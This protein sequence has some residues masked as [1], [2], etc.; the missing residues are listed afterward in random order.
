MRKTTWKMALSFLLCVVL[1]A[2][3]AL[4]FTG[5]DGSKTQETPAGEEKTFTF[6]V[7]DPEGKETAFEITTR[8]EVVGEALEAEGLIAGENGAYGLYVKTVNG[9]TLDYEKDGM[10]WAF[11]ENGG[12]AALGVD[13]TR[14]MEGVVYTF[15]A[16]AAS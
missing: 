12:Y 8:M 7:I 9:L 11:Y 3:A 2:A 5:C 14:I 4:A 15:K 13:K 6:T 1:L 10:Y 16:E